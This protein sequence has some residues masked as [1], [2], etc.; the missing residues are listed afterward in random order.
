MNEKMSTQDPMAVGR[1]QLMYMKNETWHENYPGEF[2]YYINVKILLCR[3]YYMYYIES[4]MLTILNS[5]S[6]IG[7][8]AK[9]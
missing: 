5:F 6:Y 9:H 1:C 2:I 4:Y 8:F 7:T 3:L